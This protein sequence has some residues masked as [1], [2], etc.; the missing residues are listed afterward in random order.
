MYRLLITQ[1]GNGY[2]SVLTASLIYLYDQ[3]HV[4]ISLNLVVFSPSLYGATYSDAMFTAVFI[5]FF[6]LLIHV[7]RSPFVKVYYLF[8]YLY[9][10]LVF[11]FLPLIVFIIFS[12]SIASFLFSPVITRREFY[13]KYL[14][15]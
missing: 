4:S 7:F 11:F 2:T 8:I 5:S 3:P 12:S 1:G 15:I 6:W 9:I 10:I 14:C 13:I